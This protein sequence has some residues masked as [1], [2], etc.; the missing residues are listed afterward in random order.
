MLSTLLIFI[1]TLV[2]WG[3]EFLDSVCHTG[4]T[5][6]RWNHSLDAFASAFFSDIGAEPRSYMLERLSFTEKEARFRKEME[7]LR[8]Y[9]KYDL[10]LEVLTFEFPLLL[11]YLET[12][13]FFSILGRSRGICFDFDYGYATQQRVVKSFDTVRSVRS[14]FA[15]A[16]FRV[17]QLLGPS[18]AGYRC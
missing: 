17:F 18:Y 6:S 3:G 5:M 8:S 10:T 9:T 13:V 15:Y 16:R 14:Q 12:Y 1:I 11:S 7:R 2:I 4:S